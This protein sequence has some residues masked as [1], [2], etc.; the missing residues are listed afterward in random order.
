VVDAVLAATRALVAIA[1]RSLAAAS[2][3][4]SAAGPAPASASGSDGPDGAEVTLAQFRALVVL[5]Y[6]GPQRTVDLAEELGVNSSTA[7]RLV[8]RL[9]RRGLVSRDVHPKD[10]RATTLTITSGGCDV[11]DA[12]MA[13]RRHEAGEVLGRMSAVD[14]THLL[15]GLEAFRAAAGEAPEVS[16]TLGW[17]ERAR[18][19]Q[20]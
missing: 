10:R 20:P 4:A 8:D 17:A 19:R 16:W 9:V 15:A 13:R 18:A 11:V 12:V 3:P 7:T 5:A 1:T 2:T 14:R 6:A